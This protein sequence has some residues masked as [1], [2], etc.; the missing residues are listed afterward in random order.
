MISTSGTENAVSNY[1]A[2]QATITQ[3]LTSGLSFSFN[4]TWSHFLD[5]MD[6]SSW[7]GGN[8]GTQ[9]YQNAFDISANYGASNFDVRQAFKGYVT[10]QL[11]FGT[12][13]RY[14]N[15]GGINGRILD[16][17]LGGWNAS[18]IVRAQSG[19]P[20]TPIVS[21]NESFAQDGS[22][23]PN[24]IGNPKL[25]HPNIYTGWFNPSALASPLDATFGNEHRNS[26]YGPDL[27]DVDMS[28]GKT[29][30]LVEGIKCEIRGVQAQ[31]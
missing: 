7:Q 28:L 1:N 24:V 23:Y 29:I 13:R 8:E 17:A 2:L 6:T 30:T 14:L 5:D 31:T 10:Y 26:V 20:F 15:G 18:G 16:A 22:W 11:P 4:Y 12:G 19:T 25:S 21:N 9:F 27:T 3:R